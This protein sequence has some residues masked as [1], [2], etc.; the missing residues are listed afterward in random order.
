[1]R[2]SRFVVN[3]TRN[4][5][6]DSLGPPS[7]LSSMLWYNKGRCRASPLLHSAR[8]VM[9]KLDEEHRVKENLKEVCKYQH[10]RLS[11]AYYHTNKLVNEIIGGK[12]WQG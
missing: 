1:M 5:Q 6:L 3:G 12:D 10:D 8:K 7:A 9:A 11:E 4:G 2:A